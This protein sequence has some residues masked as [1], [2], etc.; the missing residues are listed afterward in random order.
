MGICG[1]ENMESED[2][3]CTIDSTKTLV[4]VLEKYGQYRS[5]HYSLNIIASKHDPIVI[6]LDEY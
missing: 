3:F 4:H 2:R 5:L 1:I 6:D